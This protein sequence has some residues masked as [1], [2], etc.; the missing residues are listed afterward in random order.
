MVTFSQAI[1]I[2]LQEKAFNYQDRASRSEFWFYMLFAVIVDLVAQFLLIIPLIGSLLHFVVT[3]VLLWTCIM[4]GIRRL[5]DLDRRGWWIIF[6]Y[7][8]LLL[9]PYMIIL[10]AM[11]ALANGPFWLSLAL[12]LASIVSLIYFLILS[13]RRGTVGPN[14][15][16][17]DPLDIRIDG[18]APNPFGFTGKHGYKQQAYGQHH[19]APQQQGNQNHPAAQRQPGYQGPSQYHSPQSQVP[20]QAKNQAKPQ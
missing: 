11:I 18:N 19:Y 15:F 5:H 12:C 3:I 6:P 7:I 14:R 2:C 1:I 17:P 8:M 9:M 20:G 13:M 16:G 4:V 10:G